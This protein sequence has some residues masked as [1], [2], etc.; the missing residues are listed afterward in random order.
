[1]LVG[2]GW[3]DHHGNVVGVDLVGEHTVCNRCVPVVGVA[4]LITLGGGAHT[5]GAGAGVCMHTL[6]VDAGVGV[7]AGVC[8]H[9]LGG[10]AEVGANW[11]FGGPPDGKLKI[12]RGLLTARSWAW[13]LS[14]VRSACMATVRAL[15]Q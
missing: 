4:A 9:T 3:A 12:A 8:M 11:M 13:Q 1:M 14:G 2:V 6:G 15:R 10:D 7:G 5:V